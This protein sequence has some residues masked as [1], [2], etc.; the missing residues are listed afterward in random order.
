MVSLPPV[1]SSGTDLPILIFIFFEFSADQHS[2]HIF[3][4]TKI[5]SF[6]YEQFLHVVSLWKEKMKNEK[7]PENAHTSTSVTF[8][9]VVWPWPFVKVKRADVIRCLLL[10]CTLVTGM[11]SRGSMLYKIS[12]F[13]YFMWHLSFACALQHL[14]R[15]LALLSLDVFYV[16]ECLY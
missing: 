7:L 6:L 13:V 11:M 8:D 15:S 12:S 10:Y 16:E 9:L 2:L 1:E 5:G 3:G 4:K 14:S